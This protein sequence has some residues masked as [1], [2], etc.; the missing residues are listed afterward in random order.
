[1]AR[2]TNLATL[3]GHRGDGCTTSI[4]LEGT[5]RV[6]LPATWAAERMTSLTESCSRAACGCQVDRQGEIRKA[7]SSF[8][9][10]IVAMTYGLLCRWHN[11][12]NLFRPER[13]RIVSDATQSFNAV[14]SLAG[15]LRNIIGPTKRIEEKLWLNC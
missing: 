4:I 11:D 9:S 14:E 13:V 12:C 5:K 2:K 10:V 1:M 7:G 15:A 3:W 8:R 6:T